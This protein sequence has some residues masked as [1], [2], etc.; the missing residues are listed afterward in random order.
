[1]FIS[2]WVEAVSSQD[3]TEQVGSSSNT[4]HLYSGQDILSSNLSQDTG[5]SDSSLSW[6]SIVLPENTWIIPE[7]RPRVLSLTSLSIHYSLSFFDGEDITVLP[8]SLL[9]SIE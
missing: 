6:F 9:Y 4:S 8:V 3:S 1:M 2:C 7:I 5:Y